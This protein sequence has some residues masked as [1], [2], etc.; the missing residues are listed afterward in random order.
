MSSPKG[1]IEQTRKS[2]VT[3]D[4]FIIKSKGYQ[5]LIPDTHSR[6]YIGSLL[7]GGDNH[8]GNNGFFNDK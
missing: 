5:A 8:E 1:R 4:Y 3:C 7:E 6:F 2:G